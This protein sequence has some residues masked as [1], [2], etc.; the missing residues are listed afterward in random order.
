MLFNECICLD[1][2][3]IYAIPT[4]VYIFS[5]HILAD[6]S[7]SKEHVGIFIWAFLFVC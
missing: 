7:G 5:F 2:I 1:Y 4:S 3:F 6:V